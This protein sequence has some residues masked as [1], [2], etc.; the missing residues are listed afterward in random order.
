MQG[1]DLFFGDSIKNAVESTCGKAALEG[2]PEAYHRAADELNGMHRLLVHFGGETNAHLYARMEIQK[3]IRA[4]LDL[5]GE[6]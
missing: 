1:G 4:C 5:A 3:H 6:R 2:T